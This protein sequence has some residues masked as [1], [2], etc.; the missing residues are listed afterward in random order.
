MKLYSNKQKWKIALLF[1]AIILVGASLFASNKIVNEVAKRERERVTQW[2][3]AIKKRAE[4]VRLTN[5]SFEELRKKELN[6]MQLWIDAT[7]EISRK[8]SLENQQSYD[9]PLKIIN[10]NDDI[11]V[12]VLDQEDVVSTYI[13][14][15]LTKEELKNDFP[16]KDSLEIE[17]LFSDSLV[18]LAYSWEKIN[19]SFT[20]EVYDDLF[21]SYFYNDSRNILRLEEERDSLIQAFNTELIENAELVPVV[22]TDSLQ[23]DVLASNL[24]KE[25]LDSVKLNQKLSELSTENEPIKIH[26]S[27]DEVSYVFYANSPELVQLQYFPY[28]QFLIIGLFIFI[29][30]IIFSTFRK[31]EQNKVWAGMAKETAHQLGTP[32]SSLMAWVQLLEGMDNTK[33]IATEMNKDVKRLSQVTDRFSKIGASTQLKD[34]DIVHTTQHFLDYFRTRFPQKVELTFSTSDDEINIPHNAAL[35]EWV[36]E[37]ICKNAID[38]MEGKGKIDISITRN[39][40]QVIIDISDNGKGMTLSQQRTV[41]EPGFTTKKRGWGLG[42]PLA[43]RIIHEYHKGRL[44]IL[45]SEVG[46]GTTFRIILSA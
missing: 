6:E 10:R 25:E 39:Q 36:I 1:V 14:I 23:Q 24:L 42:L 46:K 27:E 40:G 5:N 43:K 34:F 8:T 19:P 29:G 28:I 20:I 15:S 4:L 11:P 33:D 16:E 2:A 3:D 26:F 44:K 7:K 30:Y 21:M 13:N 17:A 22:L 32:I 18:K 38:A 9:L 41:F 45:H 31:A 37:N 12:I 35:F